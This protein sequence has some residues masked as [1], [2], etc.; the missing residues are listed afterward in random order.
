M[1]I[2]LQNMTYHISATSMSSTMLVIPGCSRLFLRAISGQRDKEQRLITRTALTSRPVHA[3]DLEG[4]LKNGAVVGSLFVDG[5][6]ACQ[7]QGQGVDRQLLHIRWT[8]QVCFQLFPWTRLTPAEFFSV[9]P[10]RNLSSAD[11]FRGRHILHQ[12]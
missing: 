2:S 12:L 9:K 3:R 7:D 5:R 1:V 8:E 10:R 6:G 11:S 4:T